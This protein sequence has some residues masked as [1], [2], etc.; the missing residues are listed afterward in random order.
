MRASTERLELERKVS[1]LRTRLADRAAQIDRLR[2]ALV[3]VCAGLNVALDAVTRLRRI[4]EGGVVM[5][6]KIS[7]VHLLIPEQG[8]DEAFDEPPTFRGLG[9]NKCMG[10]W[11][12]A[13]GY[14]APTTRGEQ[15]A[16]CKKCLG[17]V[18]AYAEFIARGATK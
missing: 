3:E 2:A 12:G 14:V 13:S 4:A 11:C 8:Y 7:A 18:A 6:R 10:T 17:I 15:P 16:T 5:A 9:L 1:E